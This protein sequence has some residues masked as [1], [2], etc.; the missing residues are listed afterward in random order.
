MKRL[1]LAVAVILALGACRGQVPSDASPT[2]ATASAGASVP[3]VA[4]S[5]PRC[6]EVPKVSAPDEWYRDAPIYVANEQ[7]TEG[8]LAWARAQPGFEEI[9]LDRERLGWIT[10]AFSTDAEARQADLERLFPDVGVVAVA[11]D[12]TT[13]ELET[14]QRRVMDELNPIFP[15]SSWGSVQQ[16]VVGIGVG[17]LTPERVAAI[18]ERFGDERICV[19]GLD[20]SEAPP[21][22]AQQ[23]AGD[24]W[25]LLADEPGVGAP[26]TTGIASDQASYEGLWRG[27]GL[28]GE[29]P[30]VDF[31]TEVVI[32]F[33]AVYGSSCPDLRLD[34]V[35][36]DRDRALVH[37]EIVLVD[38]PM[39][40]TD[41]ANPRAYLVALERSRLP[42]EPFAIQLGPEDPPRGTPEE[43]TLVDVDLSAPG[44]VAGPGDVHGDPSL[45]GPL[46]NESGDVIEDGFPASYRFS[47]HCGI[48]W[49]GRLNE[50]EWRTEVPPGTVD[51]VPPDWERLVDP[52]G[53]VLEVEILLLTDPEPI[54]RATAGGH[55]VIYRPTT[56]EPPGC[57]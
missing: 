38:P 50:I 25:R 34:D 4:L 17:V 41:D 57:D 19:E 51:H 54:I 9:W 26:Y 37:A 48:E 8:V 46:Y 13:D 5:I 16:G 56:E 14:L 22:G 43:R 20:P 6:D 12:W 18:E 42:A 1:A 52:S 53:E 28:S 2:Q 35:V 29:M 40:C 39:M 24:G 7:P 10:L 32:Y 21:P 44:A 47:V 45:P 36:V 33:G 55:T 15:V 27:I 3:A 31:E 30:P 11:V 23:P 49:L